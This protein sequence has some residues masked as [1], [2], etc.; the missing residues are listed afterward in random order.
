MIESKPENLIGDRAYD[1]VEL[2]EELRQKGIEMIAPHR[3]N[4][5]RA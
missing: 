5:V 2:D 3:Q 4:R 1:S